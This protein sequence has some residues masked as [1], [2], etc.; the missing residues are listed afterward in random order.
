M[1]P[2]DA[3]PQKDKVKE[4]EDKVKEDK[5]RGKKVKVRGKGIISDDRGHKIE[6]D[7]FE[8]QVGQKTHLSK[9]GEKK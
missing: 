3:K 4:K 9:R 6:I 1:E 7:E 2:V 5:I 8:L